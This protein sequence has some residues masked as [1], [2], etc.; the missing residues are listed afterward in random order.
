[1]GRLWN[2]EKEK[3]NFCCICTDWSAEGQQELRLAACAR[4]A[5]LS[6]TPGLLSP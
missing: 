4:R 6:S 5:G 1:M 3:P 2:K